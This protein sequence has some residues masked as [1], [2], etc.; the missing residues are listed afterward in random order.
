MVIFEEGFCKEV[1][2]I[3]LNTPSTLSRSLTIN[4]L[5]NKKMCVKRATL[6]PKPYS[7]WGT[8]E[9]KKITCKFNIL[10]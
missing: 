2:K 7:G 1:S 6:H 5:L 10:R 9:D 3:C 4:W 8:D